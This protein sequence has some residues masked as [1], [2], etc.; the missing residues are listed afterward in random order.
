VAITD[1]APLPPLSSPPPPP[2]LDSL[3][4]RA[5]HLPAHCGTVAAE[6]LRV[7]LVLA[8]DL[9]GG[10]EVRADAVDS[11]GQA[12]LQILV[13]ARREAVARHQ[14]Y[15]IVDPSPAFVDRVTRCR[16]AGAIGLIEKDATL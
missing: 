12:A 14:P 2:P 11:I 9:D 15:A 3:V 8:A 16:L 10:I 1:P 5:V 7:R 13:A 6:D 4:D